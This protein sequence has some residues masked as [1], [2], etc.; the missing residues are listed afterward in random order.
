MKTVKITLLAFSFLYFANS[1]GQYNYYKDSYYNSKILFESGV[2]VGA[3]N[4]IT[5]IGGANSDY[6]NYINEIRKKNNRFCSSIYAAMNYQD[7]AAARIEGT[8]GEV[9]SDDS[10]ITGKSN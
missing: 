10:S 8:L 9:A 7:I 5:D 4:C 2:G 6:P 1:F 3:M